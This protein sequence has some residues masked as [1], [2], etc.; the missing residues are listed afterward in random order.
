[1]PAERKLQYVSTE[2]IG[3]FCAHVIDNRDLFVKKRIDI[4]SDELSGTEI[5]EILSEVT[6][7][8]ISYQELP[9]ETIREQS[10]DMAKMYSWFNEVGYKVDMEALKRDYPEIGWHSFKAWAK[11][12]DWSVLNA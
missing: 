10:E 3:H 7:R 4:A 8:V 1:M 5:A 12:Q 9:L 11:E 2:D 6:G